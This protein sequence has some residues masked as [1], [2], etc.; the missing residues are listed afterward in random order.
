MAGDEIDFDWESLVPRFVHPLKVAII[1][2][3][4]WIGRPLSASE[5]ARV[6][7]G[8]Y[9]LSLV[10]Y[11]LNMLVDA[12]VFEQVGERQVRG[13]VQRSYFFPG[14]LRR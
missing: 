9:N 12:D 4:R 10:A 5:L 11:H 3:M 13:A 1:E 8:E 2:A 6:F 7:L 14:A